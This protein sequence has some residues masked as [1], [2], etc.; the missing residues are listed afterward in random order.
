MTK[1]NEYYKLNRRKKP[2]LWPDIDVVRLV[3]KASLPIGGDV[4]DLGCG[5][6]RNLRFLID[7]GHKP[8][9]V[10]ASEE[11]LGLVRKL[12]GV[13]EKKL[14]CSNAIIAL[15]KIEPSTIDLVLCWG[16]SHY[17]ED[18][19]NLMRNV[20]RVIKDGG[21]LVMSFTATTDQRPRADDIEHLFTEIDVRRYM[22]E[23]HFE[24]L[25]FGKTTMT[26]YNKNITASYYWIRATK[27]P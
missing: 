24:I 22:E 7:C 23:S 10:D 4:L 3:S 17:I 1:F 15:E 21:T 27:V 9:C 13:D 18:V 19:S 12:Y 16:L 26:D 14:I 6:G 25:D 11:A 20:R 2:L 8:V 5:E